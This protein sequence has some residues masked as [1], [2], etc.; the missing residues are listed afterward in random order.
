MKLNC[1]DRTLVIFVMLILLGIIALA[2]AL[3]MSM[4]VGALQGW[5]VVS[6]F[7]LPMTFGAGWRLGTR[8]SRAHLSGLDKG[9]NAVMKA[10]GKTADLRTTTAARARQVLSTRVT[11]QEPLQLPDPQIVHVGVVNSEEVIDL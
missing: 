6:I 5:A 11:G 2:V 4:S 9:I 10:A 3:V 1:Q 7:V 8:D